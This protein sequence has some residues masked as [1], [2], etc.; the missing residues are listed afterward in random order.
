M[1][2][3]DGCRVCLNECLFS[4]MLTVNCYS[5]HFDLPLYGCFQNLWDLQ[6]YSGF[7][8]GLPLHDWLWPYGFLCQKGGFWVLTGRPGMSFCAHY[9]SKCSLFLTGYDKTEPAHGGSSVRYE[10]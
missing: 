4:E 9:S 6:S 8:C 3:K 2:G 10:H 1:N 7:G 5:R